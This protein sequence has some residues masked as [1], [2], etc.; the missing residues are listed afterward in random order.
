MWFGTHDGLNRYDGYNFK[1]Y[2]PESDNPKSINSNLIYALTGD[3][4][5]NLWVGTSGYGLNYFNKKSDTFTHYIHDPENSKSLS[6]NQVNGLLVDS[7]NYQQY[8]F[9]SNGFFTF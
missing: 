2:R 3:G 8:S 9:R 1:V 7:K 4:K 6:N 5:G